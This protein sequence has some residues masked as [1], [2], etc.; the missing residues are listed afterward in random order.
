MA[1]IFGWGG[2]SDIQAGAMGQ[3][4]DNFDTAGCARERFGFDFG[5]VRE[6]GAKSH[7]HNGRALACLEIGSYGSVNDLLALFVANSIELLKDL[8]G[9]VCVILNRQTVLQFRFEIM[10]GG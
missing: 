10:L 2:Q 1:I 6:G 8:F 9:A 7:M 4:L 5:D 3:C